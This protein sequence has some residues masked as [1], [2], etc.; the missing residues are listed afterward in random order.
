M[1]TPAETGQSD[2]IQKLDCERSND[3]YHCHPI[4]CYGCRFERHLISFA[5]LKIPAAHEPGL[6]GQIGDLNLV[7]QRDDDDA[8]GQ[9]QSL[10]QE[11]ETR[12][13]VPWEVRVAVTRAP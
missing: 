5:D 9:T 6:G 12:D 8:L 11:H 3:V 7:F 13:F 10:P 4:T 2:A 1:S